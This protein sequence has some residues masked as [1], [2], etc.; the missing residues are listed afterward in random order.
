MFTISLP[1]VFVNG[2]DNVMN[3]KEWSILEYVMIVGFALGVIIGTLLFFVLYFYFVF[4]GSKRNFMRE[5]DS[6]MKFHSNSYLFL[7][8]TNDSSIKTK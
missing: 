2:S 5:I 7:C 8:S 6:L 1:M 4:G 3:E